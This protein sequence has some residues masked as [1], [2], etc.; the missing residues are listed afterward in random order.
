MV[1]MSDPTRS[2]PLGRTHPTF[3]TLASW[4]GRRC[5]PGRVGG[6]CCPAEQ[7]HKALLLNIDMRRHTWSGFPIQSYLFLIV[8]NWE[9][10]WD[11]TI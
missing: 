2:A 5:S 3:T 8:I 1:S 6:A 4:R 11:M 9:R 7:S 10:P